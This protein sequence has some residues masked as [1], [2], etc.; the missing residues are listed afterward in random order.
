MLPTL[1]LQIIGGGNVYDINGLCP[2]VTSG[3][4]I[5]NGLKIMEKDNRKIK[6]IGSYNGHQSGNI[7]D[8]NG[9]SP[10]LCC[11]DYKSP[12]K[13]VEI[14]GGNSMNK[15]IIDNNFTEVKKGKYITTDRERERVV[16]Q[17][18]LA[19]EADQYIKNK[20]TMFWRIMKC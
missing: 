4:T 1:D 20:I 14:R 9:L 19:H 3:S 18:P 5:K 8:K 13:I 16:M 15:N 17:L 11:T 12:L 10:S 6:L 2:T 7:Y